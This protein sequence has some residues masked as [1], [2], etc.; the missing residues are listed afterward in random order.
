MKAPD[1]TLVQVIMDVGFKKKEGKVVIPEWMD[2]FN[3]ILM[4]AS[5]WHDKVCLSKPCKVIGDSS[6]FQHIGKKNLHRRGEFLSFRER[7]YRWQC[8]VVDY[9]IGG[10][11]PIGIT[12]DLQFI[13]GN[14]E[15]SISNM[16][17]QFAFGA[18]GRF[19]NVSHGREPEIIRYWYNGI[20][21]F[22]SIGW[23]LGSALKSS[24]YGFALQ[25]LTMYELG[26]FKDKKKMI[27][28]LGAVGE[29]VVVGMHYLIEQLGI[30]TEVLSFDASSSSMERFGMY[31]SPEGEQVSFSDIR[32]GAAKMTLWDGEVWDTVPA[33]L[34]GEVRESISRTNM[35]N[36]EKFWKKK[37]VDVIKEKG[38]RYNATI[39]RSGAKFVY[40]TWKELGVDG[41]CKEIDR[42]GL[43]GRVSAIETIDSCKIL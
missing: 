36:F 15:L 11:I 41:L 43:M 4:S 39:V 19:V 9:I 30:E 34:N 14:L 35:V 5:F 13:K 7:Y 17:L 27:H 38:E 29:N 6:G 37:T 2:Q 18:E 25:L 31:L 10:D 33:K 3:I 40:D 12:K 32:S 22:P 28:C 8:D 20:K 26:E 24:V 42:R 16:Q 1:P 21:H 23:A